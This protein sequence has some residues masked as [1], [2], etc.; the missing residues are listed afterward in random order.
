MLSDV[1]EDLLFEY[2]EQNASITTDGDT[3][4][5]HSLRRARAR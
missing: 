1:L 3:Q 4:P 5:R 2:V